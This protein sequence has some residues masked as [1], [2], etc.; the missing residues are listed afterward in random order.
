MTEQ[1][2]TQ[3]F[4]LTGAAKDAVRFISGVLDLLPATLLLVLASAFVVEELQS[5]G[6]VVLLP[7]VLAMV[8]ETIRRHV[9]GVE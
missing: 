1:K 2:A 3:E 5:I 7:L 9:G 6:A 8:G 4:E